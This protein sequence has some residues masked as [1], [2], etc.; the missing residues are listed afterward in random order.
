MGRVVCPRRGHTTPRV[1]AV[2]ILTTD[3]GL[4]YRELGTEGGTEGGT[5]LIPQP[6]TRS[7]T[8]MS[9]SRTL[10]SDD[11]TEWHWDR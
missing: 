10:L 1:S 8:E 4:L 9:H 2:E 7:T 6:S 5:E 3:L 11:R